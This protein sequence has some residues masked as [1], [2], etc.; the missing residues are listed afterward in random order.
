MCTANIIR[1][2]VPWTL[3]LVA[4]LPLLATLPLPVAW[5]EEEEARS[6][7]KKTKK[8][9]RDEIS[10]QDVFSLDANI[11]TGW[12][13]NVYLTPE[14]EYLDPQT[15]T[16]EK[17][18]P[19]NSFFVNADLTASMT[20]VHDK[21]WTTQFSLEYAPD[22][23][24]GSGNVKNASG[25]NTKLSFEQ[26]YRSD[27]EKGGVLKKYK[28]G[29]EFYIEKK[30]YSYLHR[31][32]GA[33]RKTAG[34]TEEDNRYDYLETGFYLNFSTYFKGRTKWDVKLGQLSRD[35]DEI[36]VLASLD[37]KEDQI[38]TKIS[39]GLDKRWEIFA[40]MD[41]KTLSYDTHRAESATGARVNGTRRKYIESSVSLGLGYDYGK[42]NS[43][44]EY[45]ASKRDDT[46]AGYW[47][48]DQSKYAFKL[49]HAVG[50]NQTCGLRLSGS[51]RKYA[52]D[53]N[54]VGQL[55]VR[56]V[57]SADLSYEKEQSW[58]NTSFGISYDDQRDTDTYYSYKRTI[59][60]IGYEREF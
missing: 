22:I 33:L 56:T 42:W 45:E 24:L 23:Y 4:I 30:D 11:Q 5:A 29:F 46:Y 36:S 15:L 28:G 25:S 8:N 17:S 9:R 44:I 49:E 6:A 38:Y 55:R 51:E 43:S 39:K 50:A 7:V 59:A 52:K 37:R 21:Y 40:D 41:L 34:G 16:Y 18:T 53:T 20:P 48:Y 27:T 32:T 14:G 47:S 13:S 3:I 19:A 10:S 31:G 58:G 12:N 60:F 54:P 26:K 2:Q 1:R 57:S 35:Y